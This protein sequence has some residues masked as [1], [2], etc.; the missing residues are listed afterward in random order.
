VL[1]ALTAFG[2]FTEVTPGVFGNNEAS[3]LFRD[4]S[5][6]LRNWA[7][8]ATSE[9]FLKSASALGHSLETG[10]AAHDHVFGQNVWEY[11]RAHPEENEAFNL[12][13]AEVRK[14]EHSEVA[15]AYDWTAV[16]AVVDVGGGAGSLIGAILA[17]HPLM[18]GTLLER[19]EVLPD[20]AHLLAQH[21]VRERCNLIAG[22]FF[23]P[24]RV[25]GD[26]WI[27]SQVLHDWP[28]A[29]CRAILG[30]CREAVRSG[31]RLLV[32]EML[33][34]PGSPDIAI[35]MIDIGMLTFAGEARQR[36]QEE[37][38]ELFAA[39]GFE[40][41]RTVPTNTAFSIVEAKPV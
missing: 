32:I 31:D 9:Q 24:I 41:T 16:N 26:R 20:A 34:V 29:E 4:S 7:L 1:R 14:D 15:R 13:L 2:V 6:G 19:P 30:R 27:L 38:N 36:T 23:D 40:H 10:E 28:D 37:Y 18:T 3:R 25:T 21:G 33:P 17:A 35:A 5:G 12:G 8:F 11:L 39:T 22:S